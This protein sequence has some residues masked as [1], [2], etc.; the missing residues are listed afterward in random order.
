M[1]VV[2]VFSTSGEK[3]VIATGVTADLHDRISAVDI[4]KLASKACGGQG[5]GGRVDFAQSGGSNPSGISAALDDIES[6]LSSN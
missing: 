3:V 1:A 5:G 4:V 2:V 6:Y